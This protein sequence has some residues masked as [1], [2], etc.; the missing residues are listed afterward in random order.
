MFGGRARRARHSLRHFPSVTSRGSVLDT[1][2]IAAGDA[3]GWADQPPETG[4]I[5]ATVSPSLISAFA[6]TNASLTAKRTLPR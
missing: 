3:I 1:R 5:N 2:A 6:P 4:G